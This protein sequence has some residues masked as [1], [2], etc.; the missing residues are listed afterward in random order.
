MGI[1]LMSPTVDTVALREQ[2]ERQKVA[3]NAQR[4]NGTPIA[5]VIRV[6]HVRFHVHPLGDAYYV[7]I[8]SFF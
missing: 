1:L 7:K 2:I 8:S 6:I 5:L 4:V 3:E